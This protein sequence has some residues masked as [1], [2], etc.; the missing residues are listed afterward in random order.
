MADQKQ[1]VYQVRAVDAFGNQRVV[2]AYLTEQQ[3]KDAAVMMKKGTHKRYIYV[4]VPNNPKEHWGLDIPD[5]VPVYGL[6]EFAPV[7]PPPT[8]KVVMKQAAITTAPV[9]PKPPIPAKKNDCGCPDKK[10]T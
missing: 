9:A 3:A 10:W 5:T 4:P 6:K 2:H 8:P 1:I 7:L